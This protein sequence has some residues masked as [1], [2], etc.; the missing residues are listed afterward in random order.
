ML[1]VDLKYVSIRLA[2]QDRLCGVCWRNVAYH[3]RCCTSLGLSTRACIPR[4]ELDLQPLTSFKSSWPQAGM[5]PMYI[6]P[7]PFNIYLSAVVANWRELSPE[8]GANVKHKQ[9]RKLVGD[10]PRKSCLSSVKVT[11]PQF[12]FH[13]SC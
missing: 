4:S 9:G 1:F 5:L 6:A 13:R 7:K 12:Q 3:Q 2:S 10:R 8:A 11:E